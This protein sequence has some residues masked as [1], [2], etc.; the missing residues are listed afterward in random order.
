MGRSVSERVGLL[1]SWSSGEQNVL[2]YIKNWGIQALPRAN[3]CF[4]ESKALNG[5]E[6]EQFTSSNW[7]K[8]CETYCLYCDDHKGNVSAIFTFLLNNE[9]IGTRTQFSV[10]V[11]TKR[12]RKLWP[13]GG[14]ELQNWT[15]ELSFSMVLFQILDSAWLVYQAV[16]WL[17]HRRPPQAENTCW[18]LFTFLL[19]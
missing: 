5:S 4:L 12:Y 7:C 17:D 14:E 8:L 9:E 3:Y 16:V 18:R 15:L 13:K 6:E 1:G 19:L 2:K 10:L 11:Y